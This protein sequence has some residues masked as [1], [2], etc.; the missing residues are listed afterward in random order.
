MFLCREPSI[1][2]RIWKNLGGASAPLAPPLDPPMGMS[3]RFI[4]AARLE[5]NLSNVYVYHN[6]L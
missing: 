6:G 1:K 4:V 2:K 5:H 3:I